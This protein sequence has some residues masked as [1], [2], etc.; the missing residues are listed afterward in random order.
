MSARAVERLDSRARELWSDRMFERWRT[1]AEERQSVGATKR[2]SSRVSEWQSAGAAERWSNVATEWWRAGTTT[3]LSVANHLQY[4]VDHVPRIIFWTSFTQH[5]HNVRHRSHAVG[6]VRA[7]LS[8]G[9][10][11]GALLS[12][13]PFL[14]KRPPRMGVSWGLQATFQKLNSSGTNKKSHFQLVL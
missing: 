6:R 2:W 14:T 10:P 13:G 1:R 4:R 5:S 11:Q 3:L 9:S 8:V 7:D 12:S